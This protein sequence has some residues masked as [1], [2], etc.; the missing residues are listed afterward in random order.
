MGAGNTTFSRTPAVEPGNSKN[1]DCTEYDENI[2]MINM[3][4]SEFVSYRDY[5]VK[6]FDDFG[7]NAVRRPFLEIPTILRYG[8]HKKTE[9]GIVSGVVNE[10]GA[11]GYMVSFSLILRLDK[12]SKYPYI[13]HL[14][15]EDFLPEFLSNNT[16]WQ[17]HGFKP[18]GISGYCS[19]IG[20]KSGD[21]YEWYPA[22]FPDKEKTY[23]HPF[24]FPWIG[25]S[26]YWTPHTSGQSWLNVKPQTFYWDPANLV[27]FNW[28]G[29]M[30]VY[31]KKTGDQ[32]S[33]GTRGTLWDTTFKL[34]KSDYLYP[35]G[36]AICQRINFLADP[37]ICCI[38]DHECNKNNV[39]SL[40]EET[41]FENIDR[42]LT[43]SPLH[44]NLGSSAC[45]LRLAPYC[46]GEKK[47][48][49]YGYKQLW[50]PT[51]IIEVGGRKAKNICYNMVMKSVYSRPEDLCSKNDIEAID[52]L[53]FSD[54]RFN[55][56]P[57]LSSILERL[58]EKV[59]SEN[60]GKFFLKSNENGREHIT[61][62]II[63]DQIL[64]ICQ[65]AP[66]L[67]K[68][69]LPNICA[70]VTKKNIGHLEG[71][72][73]L[74]GCY[75]DITEY[76]NPGGAL[77]RE[78]LE[79]CVYSIN[80]GGIP[81]VDQDNNVKYCSSTICVMGIDYIEFLNVRNRETGESYN[82]NQICSMC[83][84]NNVYKK[85]YSVNKDEIE[86]QESEGIISGLKKIN[87]EI[88]FIGNPDIIEFIPINE[89][90]LTL[91]LQRSDGGE[92]GGKGCE[93]TLQ[94]ITKETFKSILEDYLI[95]PN[96]S[97]EY[98]AKI[99]NTK[100]LLDEKEDFNIVSII[101]VEKGGRGY[102]ADE[103]VYLEITVPTFAGGQ[104]K[105][106]FEAYI[107][108]LNGY[109]YM[110]YDYRNENSSCQCRVNFSIY[111]RDSTIGRFNFDQNCGT[112]ECYDEE[113]NETRDCGNGEGIDS[114]KDAIDEQTRDRKENQFAEMFFFVA[115]FTIVL[116]VL[117][118]IFYAINRYLISKLKKPNIKNVSSIKKIL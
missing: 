21:E 45:M 34:V 106:N 41:C 14:L 67:C 75:M 12:R 20:K 64:K 78:C 9:F 104:A 59:M 114:F 10:M 16:D 23:T 1:N 36:L 105:V 33:T 79:Y 40:N 63:K 26:I 117:Y 22:L 95:D 60:G 91:E 81:L 70:N 82:F 90:T 30:P 118:I 46:S 56:I 62:K 69:I 112:I 44:R 61:T 4:E 19:L 109:D 98:K 103:K 108:S 99:I 39:Y 32:T 3:L 66:I 52:S 74:C 37:I 72:P 84:E 13:L 68:T 116:L 7:E 107:Y 89:T 80:K 53:T 102:E 113:T 2:D 42:N 88:S 76:Y 58:A 47:L 111:A 15:S 65:K 73:T 38:M 50:S 28:D 85:Y 57:E 5:R 97:E 110:G 25:Q 94:T 101:T 35:S 29:F 24:G 31:P 27:S 93:V 54:I 11:S 86:D 77:P 55:N 92:E 87:T 100:N 96:S 17:N 83:G 115:I 71:A 8:E 43:C 48:Y 51:A 6:H 49:K 18:K